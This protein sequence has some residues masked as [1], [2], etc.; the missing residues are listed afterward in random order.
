MVRPAASIAL[1]TALKGQEDQGLAELARALISTFGGASRLAQHY[2]VEFEAA[3]I[4]GMARQRLLEG[5]LR[6]VAQA[7]EKKG[8]ALSVENLSEE[9][10]EKQLEDILIR[11]GLVSASTESAGNNEPI[12]QPAV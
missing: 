10:L 3:K 2:L 1:G 6:I 7:S 11:R 5:V 8:P 4:G 12:P 9:E